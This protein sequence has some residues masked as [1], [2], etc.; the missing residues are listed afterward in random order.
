MTETKQLICP[1]WCLTLIY[2]CS[3][4]IHRDA[5]GAQKKITKKKKSDVHFLLKVCQASCIPA[6]RSNNHVHS[7][8]HLR[9]PENPKLCCKSPILIF[10]IN[11]Y[12]LVPTALWCTKFLLWVSCLHQVPNQG[13]PSTQKCITH[14]TCVY[15]CRKKKRFCAS[16]SQQRCDLRCWSMSKV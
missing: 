2:F 7:H 5:T 11:L 13:Q 12:Q 10:V 14:I 16:V 9:N 15:E 6:S 8:T 1:H 4:I 3:E